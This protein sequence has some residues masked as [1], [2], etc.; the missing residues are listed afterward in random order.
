MR[1]PRKLPLSR[2]PPG[3]YLPQAWF[4]PK[5]LLSSQKELVTEAPSTGALQALMAKDPRE[6]GPRNLQ[7]WILDPIQKRGPFPY[8]ALA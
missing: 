3:R 7:N 5:G 8:I 6:E 4:L 1:I 2:V